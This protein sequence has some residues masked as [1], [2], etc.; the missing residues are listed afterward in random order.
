MLRASAKPDQLAERLV[1]P[2]IERRRPPVAVQRLGQAAVPFLDL[3]Q[4]HLPAH[5]VRNPRE[6]GPRAV[7]FAEL[8]EAARTVDRGL[9]LIQGKRRGGLES[10]AR[11]CWVAPQYRAVAKPQPTMQVAG[12][13]A[14]DAQEGGFGGAKLARRLHRRQPV[15]HEDIRH[16]DIRASVFSLHIHNYNR[17]DGRDRETSAPAPWTTHFVMLY[18]ITAGAH[19]ARDRRG[20]T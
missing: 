6:N 1:R 13:R 19:A 10:V 7:A 15:K 20:A 5:R 18:R 3:A 14:R 16:K 2:W 8:G 4:R 11:A 9:L 17:D 12:R